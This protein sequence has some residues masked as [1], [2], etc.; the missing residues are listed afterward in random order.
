MQIEKLGDQRH[1]HL[2]R[3]GA[4]QIDQKVIVKIIHSLLFVFIIFLENIAGVQSDR[5]IG[6]KG[7]VPRRQ[8]ADASSGSPTRGSRK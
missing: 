4:S 7:R 5:A 3:S 8:L 1:R 6:V 2:H